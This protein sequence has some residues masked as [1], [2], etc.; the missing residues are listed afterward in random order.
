MYFVGKYYYQHNLWFGGLRK[1][2]S[3]ANIALDNNDIIMNYLRI[4]MGTLRESSNYL[5]AHI[6]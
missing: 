5:L 6:K 3:T 1:L 2:N 4:A